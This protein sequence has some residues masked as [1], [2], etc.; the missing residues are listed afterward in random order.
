MAKGTWFNAPHVCSFPVA[1]FEPAA[2]NPRLLLLNAM[3]AVTEQTEPR[4]AP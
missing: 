4:V 2:L 3:E 1:T